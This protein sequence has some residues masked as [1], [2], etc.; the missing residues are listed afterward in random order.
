LPIDLNSALY[1]YET[2]LAEFYKS[3]RN[4]KKSN[5]FILQSE[6]RR[7]KMNQLMWNFKKG[8]YFDYDY[9]HKRQSPFYSIAGFYPM[10]ARLATYT[11]A[12]K[13][14][15]E[16]G[17]ANTQAN[18]LSE[19]YKQHD[20]PNGWPHQQWIVVRGLM[21][22]NFRSDAERIAKKFLDLNKKVFDKT[23][24]LWEK[25]NVV[26]CDIGKSERYKTQWGFA[27]TNAVFIRLLDKFGNK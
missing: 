24:K 26:E 3:I 20:Y 21:N 22:Y 9:K 7:R 8:F 4:I 6:K 25:Y 14:V 27:W 16:G 2:D 17:L 5:Q 13:M 15:Y 19:E 12:K 10:W 1:K 23:G 11:Q 18:N